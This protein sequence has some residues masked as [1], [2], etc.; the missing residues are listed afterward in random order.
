MGENIDNPHKSDNHWSIYL[1]LPERM[2]YRL[3]AYA[4]EAVHSD[5]R[6]RKA[7]ISHT[8]V[9]YVGDMSRSMNVY[10]DFTARKGLM[11]SHVLDLI[12]SKGRDKYESPGPEDSGCRYWV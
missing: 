9:V 3:H 11:V 4:A 2:Q 12:T 5:A 6:W 10:W 7:V 1:L 8:V